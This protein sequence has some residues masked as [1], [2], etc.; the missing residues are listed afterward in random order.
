M[1]NSNDKCLIEHKNLINNIRNLE[2]SFE[3]IKNCQKRTEISLEELQI[4]IKDLQEK[5]NK[6]KNDY[7]SKIK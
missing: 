4:S 7:D 2:I 3:E 1:S 6:I 5:I